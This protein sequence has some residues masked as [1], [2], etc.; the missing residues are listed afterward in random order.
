MPSMKISCL[1]RGNTFFGT[2]GTAG[3]GSGETLVTVEY[4][5]GVKSATADGF[6]VQDVAETL[7]L[8]LV[9]R[10]AVA[11]ERPEWRMVAR[12]VGRPEHPMDRP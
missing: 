12:P 11:R 8:E 2:F 6:P 7:L 10:E 3:L 1:Y 5:E 9:V 4:N